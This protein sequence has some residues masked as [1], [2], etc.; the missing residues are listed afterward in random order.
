MKKDSTGVDNK[1]QEN[2]KH[3]Y[4]TLSGLRPKQLK[5]SRAQRVERI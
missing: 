1:L 5:K 3:F 4:N 2:T